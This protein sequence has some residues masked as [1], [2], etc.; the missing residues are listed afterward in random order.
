MNHL[1]LLLLSV[2]MSV[3]YHTF[4]SYPVLVSL[5]DMAGF[6]IHSFNIVFIKYIS[7]YI[8]LI[9][10]MLHIVRMEYITPS[11]IYNTIIPKQKHD[12]SHRYP[13][14][15]KICYMLCSQPSAQ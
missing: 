12:C 14:H 11:S 1:D 4:I 3:F 6:N 15:A 9:K 7:L 2:A 13:N 5:V 8:V 10:Y